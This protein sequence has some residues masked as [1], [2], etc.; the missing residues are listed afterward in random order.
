VR[1]KLWKLPKVTMILRKNKK[2]EKNIPVGEDLLKSENTNHSVNFQD[3]KLDKS[4]P[5]YA[6]IEDGHV[7]G[8]REQFLD[9]PY[10]NISR[11]KE[12]FYSMPPEIEC[13]TF[14][15]YSSLERGSSTTSGFSS[16]GE[17]RYQTDVH[18]SPYL[19]HGSP[20]R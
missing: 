12:N 11:K 5:I 20:Y 7:K 4:E 9:K 18:G 3:D 13:P 2:D 15:S 17:W 10:E 19:E 14:K 1:G 6:E 16:D 8:T